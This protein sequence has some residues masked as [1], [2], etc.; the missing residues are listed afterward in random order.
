VLLLAL[1]ALALGVRLLQAFN[2]SARARAQD[3]REQRR[4]WARAV[5]AFASDASDA[6][7]WAWM[8]KPKENVDTDVARADFAA[9]EREFRQKCREF[10]VFARVGLVHA[11][12]FERGG[13]DVRA[14][15]DRLRLQLR[16]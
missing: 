1:T 5:Q 2:A 7:L 10:M 3:L 4:Q 6:R 13:H 12:A 8:T 9:F 15:L 11:D 16:A 14:V